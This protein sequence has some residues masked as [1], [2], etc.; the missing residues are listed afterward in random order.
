MQRNV[1][2]DP[3]PAGGVNAERKGKGK[4][5]AK[6]FAQKK[7]QSFGRIYLEVKES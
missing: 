7:D 1:G 6:W 4:G 3:K 5:K 2:A